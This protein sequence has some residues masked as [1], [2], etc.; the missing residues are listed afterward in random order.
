[1]SLSTKENN[2]VKVGIRIRPI[3]SSES[4]QGKCFEEILKYIYNILYTTY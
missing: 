2:R 1:M 3:S 4:D